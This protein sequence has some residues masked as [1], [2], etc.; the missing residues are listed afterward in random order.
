MG[1]VTLRL[2]GSYK[3]QSKRRPFTIQKGTF[4]DVKGRI[5]KCEYEFILHYKGR[6]MLKHQCRH[7]L[8]PPLASYQNHRNTV[9]PPNLIS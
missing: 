4:Y 6:Y 9:Y 1:F 2:S 7:K 8:R 3:E 5:L